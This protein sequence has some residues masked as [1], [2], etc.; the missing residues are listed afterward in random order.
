MKSDTDSVTTVLHVLLLL[1]FALGSIGTI[2]YH[3]HHHQK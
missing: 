1:Y 2:N 3:H